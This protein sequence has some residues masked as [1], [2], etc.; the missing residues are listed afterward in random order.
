MDFPLVHPSVEM[1]FVLETK[2]AIMVTSLAALIAWFLQAITATKIF[3]ENLFATQC[4]ET[5]SEQEQKHAITDSDVAV[6]AINVL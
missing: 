1:E 5:T 2:H 3:I 4:V 6:I